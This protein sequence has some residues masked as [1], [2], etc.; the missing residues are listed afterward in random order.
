[1]PDSI[2]ESEQPALPALNEALRDSY[3]ADSD[4]GV[5]RWNEIIREAGIDFELRD[6]RIARFAVRSGN[7]AR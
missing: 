2:V 6:C 7:S 1:M 3:I 5:A 4:R